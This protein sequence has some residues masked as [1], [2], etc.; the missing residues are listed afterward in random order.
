M[1]QPIETAPKDGSFILL[2][3]PKGRMADG[4]WS[5]VYEVWVWSWPYVM[6]EPTHWMPLPELPGAHPK[7]D[8]GEAGH[9]E[10]RCGNRQCLSGAQPAT[11]IPEGW[12]LVPIEPTPTMVKAGLE[13]SHV[14]NVHRVLVCY[15]AMIDAAPEAKP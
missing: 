1:W 7:P 13:S 4:F 8:C 3:T 6:V 10:G 12:T 5:P 15:D 2:A 11:S 9:D 14:L